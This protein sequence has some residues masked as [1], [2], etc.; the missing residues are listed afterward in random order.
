MG[1][2]CISASVCRNYYH[3]FPYTALEECISA[4]PEDV[5]EFEEVNGAY[6]CKPNTYLYYGDTSMSC[7]T[8]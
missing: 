4:P 1:F 3:Q 5:S 7:Y 8:K 2:D 6:T